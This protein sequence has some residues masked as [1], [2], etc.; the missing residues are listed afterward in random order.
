[1]SYLKK[2]SGI[3]LDAPFIIGVICSIIIFTRVITGPALHKGNALIVLALLVGLP[4]WGL[5]E[6]REPSDR[7]LLAGLLAL[8]ALGAFATT[9]S[10][11]LSS[12]V[13]GH[14]VNREY[15]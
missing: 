12:T 6:W 9:I 3:L 8:F 4:M 11:V 5:Y 2:N 14:S 10:I 15:P 7:K 1:M 13:I